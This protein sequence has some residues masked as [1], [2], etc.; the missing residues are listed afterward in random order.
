M[1]NIPIYRAKELCSDT[2]IIG[3]YVPT[4][5]GRHFIHANIDIDDF[6]AVCTKAWIEIDLTTLSINFPNMLDSQ[7][8]KIFASL[9]EDGKGGDIVEDYLINFDYD[10]YII[11]GYLFFDNQS[12][13]ILVHNFFERTK[14]KNEQFASEHRPKVK[15]SSY[16][17]LLRAKAVG[18]QQ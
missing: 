11:K 2:Y 18:I 9:S 13:A 4:L 17:S 5:D 7:G 14:R 15:Y 6:G 12:K 10:E 3:Y 8:N 16:Q 1:K